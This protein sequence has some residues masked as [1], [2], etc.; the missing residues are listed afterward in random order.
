MAEDYRRKIESEM[1]RFEA[2]ISS[3]SRPPGPPGPPSVTPSFIPA[4]LRRHP[5]P[6]VI[7]AAPVINKPPQVMLRL[8]IK[9][10]D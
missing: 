3:L 9:I 6:A 10:L 8:E 1:D 2:E 4:Q 5:S 7:A